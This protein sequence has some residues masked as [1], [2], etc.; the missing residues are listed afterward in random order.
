MSYSEQTIFLCGSVSDKLRRPKRT[1][2]NDSWENE[3]CIF[4]R[5]QYA[6]VTK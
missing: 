2:G 6:V 1:H 5:K 4:K 3:V